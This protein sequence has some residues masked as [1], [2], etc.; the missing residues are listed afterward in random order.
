ME[1]KTEIRAEIILHNITRVEIKVLL[2]SVE[3]ALAS[4]LILVTR[5]S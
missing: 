1:I 2:L 4:F 3:I 5:I